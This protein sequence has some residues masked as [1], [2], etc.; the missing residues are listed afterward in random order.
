MCVTAVKQGSTSLVGKKKDSFISVGYTNW[1]DAAGEKHGGFP[2]HE[3]SEVSRISSQNIIF[4]GRQGLA[5]RGSW[6]QSETEVGGGSEVDSNF[7]QLMLLRA[8]DDPQIL[9]VMSQKT[10]KYTDHHI[11]NELLKIIALEHLCTIASNIR[12]SGYFALE[13]DEVTDSSNK[14]QVIVCLRWD[15]SHLEPHE[16]FVG[17]HYVD[18]ITADTIVHV[19]TDTVLRLNLN[20]S[21]CRAQ[22][23]D[24]ASNMKKTAQE[25]KA[26]EPHA[27]YLHCYGHSLNLAVADTLKCIRVMSDALDHSFE[28]CK[29]LKFSPRRDA[30]KLKADISPGVPGLRSLCPTRWTVR[31]ASVESIRLNY[32]SLQ[33]T[34]EEAVTVV[35]DTEV[36]ARINGVASLMKTFNFLFGLMLAER[37]LKHTDN[38]SRT[39]QATSMSAIEAQSISQ[40]CVS[41]LRSFRTD[42]N[43]DLFWDLV[44]S[45]QQSLGLS[46]PV[47]PRQRKR[48]HA[49]KGQPKHFFQA[50][51]RSS[52]KPFILNLSMLQFRPSRIVLI[53]RISTSMQKWSK[54]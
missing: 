17:L 25:I 26:I 31:A 10:C 54:F 4:L 27:L 8:K 49:M 2:T 11:H 9:E 28:I 5:F 29:L 46:D 33:A 3:R 6:V 34:W 41:V 52:T 18:N 42:V 45:T 36:K 14:E 53:R 38:L 43:F 37:I 51:R 23:Y 1:K 32:E 44:I 19:L 12:T 22:C 15:D 40:L 21:M 30:L 24:G 47:L 7:H 39:L 48:P 20:M 16:D 35:R 13:S 50:T